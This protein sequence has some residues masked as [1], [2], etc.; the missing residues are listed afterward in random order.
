MLNNIICNHV[1]Y[2]TSAPKRFF[3]SVGDTECDTFEV[4]GIFDTKHVKCYEGKLVP[5]IGH[6]GE[7][8]LEGR[9]DD[10]TKEGDYYI[11]VGALKSRCFVIYDK[12]YSNAI[13]I[14]LSYFTYQRCGDPLGWGESCHTDDGYLHE[15][16]EH[17]D[18]F[19]GYH[20]SCDL[21]KSPSGISIG[22]YGMIRSAMLDNTTWG[23][24]LFRDEIIH[25]CD[26][27][28]KAIADNGVMY[29]TLNYPFG[30]DAREFFKSPPPASGQWNATRCLALASSLIPDRSEEYLK[31]ALRS[32]AYLT[33]EERDPAPYR[34]PAEVPQG[35]DGEHFFT[36]IYK[37]S[38]A[39]KAYRVCCSADLYRVTGDEKY[40]DEVK[41]AEEIDELKLFVTCCSSSYAWAPA[42]IF[43]FIDAYELLGICKDKIE[44]IAELVAKHSGEDIW[45]RS[46]RLY[47]DDALDQP[48]ST[49]DV[50]A[51]ASLRTTLK[52]LK[53]LNEY[54]EYY[55]IFSAKYAPGVDTLISIFMHKAARLLNNRRYGELAQFSADYLLG[56]NPMDASH[57]ECVGYN[58]PE[59]GVFGQ[60]FPSTPQIPGG[61]GIGFTCEDRRHEY[62]MP[63]VGNAMWLL[64]EIGVKS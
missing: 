22:V 52:N 10:L 15:T 31:A 47:D 19:G 59:R 8:Y 40:L 63:C 26:F 50:K 43:A 62:D 29:N 5:R 35:M 48:T 23:K 49:W 36:K 51:G 25:A 57:V 41:K 21:R 20:Q 17:I 3:I 12:A 34:H 39:D 56:C 9:F 27:Y 6:K 14:M 53:S 64:S 32:Y 7:K 38:T 60:F 28:V 61:I 46:I 4:I 11:T 58:Q 42:G 2:K 44:N 16:G 54:L 30:W 33:S 18:L 24:I 1:G 55:Y 13:R 45:E 37:N